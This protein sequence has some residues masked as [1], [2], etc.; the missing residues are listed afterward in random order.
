MFLERSRFGMTL[1]KL[2][3]KKS[4]P[5]FFTQYLITPYGGHM[6]R[7]LFKGAVALSATMDLGR[8]NQRMI[9]KQ[10]E[11]NKACAKDAACTSF[12]ERTYVPS[13]A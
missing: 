12:G 11:K 1:R 10:K 3:E 7:G 2:L 8:E 4:F 6:A 13:R 9:R 5:H